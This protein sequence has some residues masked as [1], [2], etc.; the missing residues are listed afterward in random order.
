VTPVEDILAVYALCILL[1]WLALFVVMSSI[2]KLQDLA[3]RTAIMTLRPVEPWE[4]PNTR[5]AA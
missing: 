5:I 2:S 1:A 4:R 3:R